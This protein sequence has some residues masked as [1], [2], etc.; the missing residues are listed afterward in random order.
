MLKQA[1]AI[2][3]LSVALS[4]QT[5]DTAGIYGQITDQSHAAIAGVQVTARNK[6]TGLR[7]TVQTDAG[8][9]YSMAGLPVAGSYEVTAAK[10]G[11][12]EGHLDNVKLAGGTAAALDL[13][14]HV[15]GGQTSVMVT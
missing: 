4:A 3:L 15:A 8:G 5:P 6:Q 10:S 7:R 11:F 13:E 2:V 12:A 9:S 14:M 1:A